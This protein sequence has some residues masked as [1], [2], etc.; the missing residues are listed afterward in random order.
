[1]RLEYVIL[2]VK[3]ILETV[4]FETIKC[5]KSATHSTMALHEVTHEF[6]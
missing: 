6:S 4:T 2:C 5:L 1:M 3:N